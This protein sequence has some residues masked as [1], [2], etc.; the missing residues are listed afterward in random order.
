MEMQLVEKTW[1]A[2]SPVEPPARVFGGETR[3]YC[4]QLKSGDAKGGIR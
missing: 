2:E 3:L 4:N 1:L